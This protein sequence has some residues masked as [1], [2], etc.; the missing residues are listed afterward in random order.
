MI[1]L[2]KENEPTGFEYISGSI[3]RIV[4]IKSGIVQYDV[5][6][7]NPFF[8][9]ILLHHYHFIVVLGTVVSRN[10]KLGK[11]MLSIGFHGTIQPVSENS[12]DLSS[13]ISCAKHKPH[14]FGRKI[15]GSQEDRVELL[16]SI[17]PIYRAKSSHPGKRQNDG[18]CF[19]EG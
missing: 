19:E 14:F 12:R 11:L 9:K 7:G 18:G 13:P 16:G 8:Q 10:Q 15:F 6:C 1:A 4:G 17:Y 5:F 2:S 3:E